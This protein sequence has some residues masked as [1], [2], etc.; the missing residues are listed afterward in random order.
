MSAE[1]GVDAKRGAKHEA[2]LVMSA[3][4]TTINWVFRLVNCP[5]PRFF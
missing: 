1:W 2:R 5:S 3:V 4:R